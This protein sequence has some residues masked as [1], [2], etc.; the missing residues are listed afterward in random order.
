MKC[1]AVQFAPEFKRPDRNRPAL[2]NLVSQAAAKGAQ[3]VV[4]PELCTTG[5]GFMSKEE[6][7]E[8]SEPFS[9]VLEPD[10]GG[11]QSSLKAL[12]ILARQ[13]N[14]AL[15]WGFVERDPG[16]GNLY[17]SQAYTDAAGTSLCYRKVN[18]FGNDWLWAT[19]GIANPPIATSPFG[20][21]IGLLVCRD[22]RNKVSDKW[23]SLYEPGDCDVVALSA[24]WG[25]GGFP[26]TAWMDFVAATKI[27]LV[28]S[29][30]YGQ[31]GPNNFGEGGVCVIDRDLKVS[32]QGLVWDQDCLVFG[33]V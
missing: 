7:L 4:L 15:V 17:N 27:P 3:L 2:L 5:Y 11:P 19:P 28:V 13:L 21:R 20:K 1:C 8:F 31:E 22:I 14:I 16:T 30:R 29:N 23:T 12:T 6:A 18:F 33:D 26:A 10:Q 25:D 32:C 24:A 9:I